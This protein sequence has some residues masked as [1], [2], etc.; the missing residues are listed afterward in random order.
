[1]GHE[2]GLDRFGKRCA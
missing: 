1:M 2:V